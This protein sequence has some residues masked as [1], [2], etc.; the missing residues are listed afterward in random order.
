MRCSRLKKKRQ[1]EGSSH[2]LKRLNWTK[3]CSCEV[4]ITNVDN[5]LIKCVVTCF[6]LSTDMVIKI[7]ET[8]AKFKKEEKNYIYIFIYK[9]KPFGSIFYATSW[10]LILAKYGSVIFAKLYCSSVSM[11]MCQILK[12]KK[13]VYYIKMVLLW[14]GNSFILIK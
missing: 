10:K 7:Y 11:R 12:R 14:N 1:H 3:H 13:K 9:K 4:A 8:F 2:M 5:V 6:V